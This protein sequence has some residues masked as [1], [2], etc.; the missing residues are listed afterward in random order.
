FV[1]RN[2]DNT[3][4]YS[5]LCKARG[6]SVL[7]VIT[8]QT[9]ETYDAGDSVALSVHLID[10]REDAIRRAIGRAIDEH[11]GLVAV[12]CGN[13]P[14]GDGPSSWKMDEPTWVRFHNLCAE[15]VFARN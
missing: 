11:A 15:E 13:E 12:E 5:K 2:T 3:R 1:L 10:Q 9:L 4:D 14:D 8:N 7:G 6:F